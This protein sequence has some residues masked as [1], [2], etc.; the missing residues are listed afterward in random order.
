MAFSI[1]TNTIRRLRDALV[2][3]GRLPAATGHVIAAQRQAT[4]ERVAPFAETM[5]LVMMADDRAD[6]AEHQAIRGAIGLLADGMLDEA[7]IDELL[8]RCAGAA[9]QQGAQTLLQQIGARVCAVRLDR[10]TAFT[11]AAAVALADDRVA[12]TESV[13]VAT[14]A[15]W[16]GISDRR[17][18]EILGE[19]EA[20]Q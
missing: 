5:Y 16:Y 4:L 12:N 7:C 18:A 3:Q 9:Q 17:C 20:G 1:D 6:L 11:L 2:T 13:L 8:Q 15:E 14:I 10:E 19:L